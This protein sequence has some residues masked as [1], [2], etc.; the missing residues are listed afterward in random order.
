MNLDLEY[1]A[2]ESSPK[3]PQRPP[4][5]KQLSK[6]DV[7]RNPVRILPPLS[8]GTKQQTVDVSGGAR[9][10][11]GISTNVSKISNAPLP[12]SEEAL[13]IKREIDDVLL[14]I[15]DEKRQKQKL[16][17]KQE[18]LSKTL[19]SQRADVEALRKKV[20]AWNAIVQAND[21]TDRAALQQGVED[22]CI[23]V[24]M[25]NSECT[26]MQRQIA[27]L[28]CQCQGA[29]A[30]KVQQK[31]AVIRNQDEAKILRTWER[32]VAEAQA[33]L[34]A[35]LPSNMRNQSQSSAAGVV[36]DAD[37]S[38]V[39]LEQ[40]RK[41][42]QSKISKAHEDV[43]REAKA[44]QASSEA[45]VHAA[46][47]AST[48]LTSELAHLDHALQQKEKTLFSLRSDVDSLSKTLA[49]LKKEREDCEA[50]K[51][52]V[53]SSITALEANLSTVQGRCQ[54][55]SS[56]LNQLLLLSSEAPVMHEK[57]WAQE[58]S[59]LQAAL[60]T[61]LQRLSKLQADYDNAQQRLRTM[62]AEA[63]L[64][65]Q[66]ANELAALNEPCQTLQEKLRSTQNPLQS[67]LQQSGELS[68]KTIIIRDL[69]QA[70][71]VEK[72]K[73]DEMDALNE[74]LKNKLEEAKELLH[75]HGLDM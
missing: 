20:D 35:Q 66:L 45:A 49:H 51:K 72:R 1:A 48:S 29:S 12:L 40:V 75:A 34:A 65:T 68:Q 18:Q 6:H 50:E 21:G 30:A 57:A 14:A 9:G 58:R 5:K 38:A 15:V 69:E 61:E 19:V 54:E 53:R 41:E 70:V 67:E 43:L 23:E 59:S 37:N 17:V 22:F 4:Q 13:A 71:K 27:S 36:S 46:S 7:N 42:Y 60:N 62:Q 47:K 64:E 52:L 3:K 73:R 2:S 10:G 11:A 8:R 26:S 16:K 31:I 24:D 74:R 33:K 39:V 25:L 44:A 28:S 55:L 32:R 63:S 56:A